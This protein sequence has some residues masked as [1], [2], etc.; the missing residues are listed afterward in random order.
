ML[1]AQQRARRMFTSY[2]LFKLSECLIIL[3]LHA[4]FLP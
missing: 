3:K 1:G 4:E 2:G